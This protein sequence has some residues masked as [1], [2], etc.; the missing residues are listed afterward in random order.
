MLRK[1]IAG[2]T[3]SD[4][5]LRQIVVDLNLNFGQLAVDVQPLSASRVVELNAQHSLFLVMTTAASVTLTLPPAAEVAGKMLTAKKLAAA[6]TLTLDA[7]GSE[8]I[9]GS[10]T[11]A[12]TTQWD[13]RTL[14]TDGVSWYVIA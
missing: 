3:F 8:T 13:R 9:D 12:M 7:D 4:Q 5:V 2:Q 1:I 6:N 14:Y 10:L 11:L